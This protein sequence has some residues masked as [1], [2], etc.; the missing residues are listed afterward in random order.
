MRIGRYLRDEPRP[1]PSTAAQPQQHDQQQ[2]PPHQQAEQGRAAKADPAA[3]CKPLGS[4]TL[5]LQRLEVSIQACSYFL[6]LQC[7]PYW[8]RTASSAADTPLQAD[9][10][11]WQIKVPVYE[12]AAT[13]TA[14]VFLE[15]RSLLG[16]VKVE[17]RP[18]CKTQVLLN[19]LPVNQVGGSSWADVPGAFSLS[20]LCCAILCCSP[21]CRCVWGG[22]AEPA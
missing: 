15:H 22:L 13:L 14:V 16:G 17:P 5:T 21:R 8:V 3:S 2:Y 18:V 6:V 19:T 9:Q 10:G 4:I 11:P 1:G 12:P 7:G 20:V